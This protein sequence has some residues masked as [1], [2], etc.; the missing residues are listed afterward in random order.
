RRHAQLIELTI[1][2]GARVRCTPDHRFMLRDGTYKA[3]E[4]LTEEDS[5]MPG[6]FDA[7]PVKE[8]L[9]DYLRVLQ[10]ETGNHE[11]VHHLADRFNEQKGLARKFEG[12]FVRHHKNF[13]RW[14]NRPTNI[15]RL[16]FLE[17]LHLH[18]E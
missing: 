14:D 3:A 15:E 8:G 6:Y 16:E 9:N 4:D 1:D 10:P 2:S 11:F 7:V 13:N 12:A 17:H 5:L 18:A